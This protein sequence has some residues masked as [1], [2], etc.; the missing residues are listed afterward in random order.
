MYISWFKFIAPSPTS[1][2]SVQGYWTLSVGATLNIGQCRTDKVKLV[3][4]CSEPGEIEESGNDMMPKKG[5]TALSAGRERNIVG[6]RMPWFEVSQHKVSEE[7][8]QMEIYS[9]PDECGV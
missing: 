8:S 7:K 6:H 2:L 1:P 9:P 4:G 5:G 3:A